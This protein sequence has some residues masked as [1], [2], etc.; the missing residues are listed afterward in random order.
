MYQ[1]CTILLLNSGIFVPVYSRHSLKT[2]FTTLMLTDS[3]K[4]HQYYRTNYTIIVQVPSTCAML[5][6]VRLHV[7]Q[8]KIAMCISSWYQVIV[9]KILPLMVSGVG[10]V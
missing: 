2:T 4:I 1:P 10:R 9:I 7:G 8:P 6:H 5:M 3:T